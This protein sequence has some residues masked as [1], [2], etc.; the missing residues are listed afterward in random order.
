MVGTT[1]LYYQ[2]I[3]TIGTGGMGVVYLALDERLNRRNSD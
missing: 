2:V 1:V 3:R